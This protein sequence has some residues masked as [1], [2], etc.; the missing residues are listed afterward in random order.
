MKVKNGSRFLKERRTLLGLEQQSV[1]SSIGVKW[2]AYRQWE[3]RGEI[4]EKYLSQISAVLKV[5]VLD[6]LI[7]KYKP[8]L[9]VT[10]GI[11]PDTIELF[12][13]KNSRV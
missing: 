2:E 11:E 9:E 10:F 3:C 6:L 12:I 5:S 13:R 4:P 7:A 1:A 8:L